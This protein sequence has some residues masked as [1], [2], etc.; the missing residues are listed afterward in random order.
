MLAARKATVNEAYL[1][2]LIRKNPKLALET[3]RSRKGYAEDEWGIGE[4]LREALERQAELATEAEVHE[5][6]AAQEREQIG[7]AIDTTAEL[8]KLN[9]DVGVPPSAY[10][11]VRDA[12]KVDHATGRR[13]EAEVDNA[14]SASMRRAERH[15]HVGSALAEGRNVKWVGEN[16]ESLDAHIEAIA[17][18]GSDETTAISRRVRMAMIAGTTPPKMQGHILKS[19]RARDPATR[20]AGVR[21]LRMLEDADETGALT[22]WVPADRR[23]FGRRFTAL[24]ASGYS[25]AEAL[26]RL[27]GADSASPV[28]E[29]AR[30]HHF[31]THV[32]L[33]DVVDAVGRAFGIEPN[34]IG[35]Y[36]AEAAE[37]RPESIIPTNA[38]APRSDW[39]PL[40]SDSR[41]EDL[42]SGE[43]LKKSDTQER[44][45]D[46]S[47]GNVAET[48]N[49]AVAGASP[50]DTTLGR[51]GMQVKGK[52]RYV[53]TRYGWVDLQHVIS[54]A[55][56]T[57]DPALNVILGIVTEGA[58]TIWPKYWPS[59]W[60]KEDLLSN[61]IG[62]Q[63][64]ARQRLVGGTIG[65]AV[66][67]VLRR[68]DPLTKEEAEKFLATGGKAE[69]WHDVIG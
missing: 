40:G 12:Y 52:G 14:R 2:G 25:D 31:D 45:G 46:Y 22:A 37:R 15:N 1:L 3:L 33:D 61:W 56:A 62:A 60:K 64:L 50:W 21:M 26:K 28:L 59:A 63:A 39:S 68:Y 44:F 57:N 20:A 16:L 66:A 43:R 38:A 29:E 67:F 36:D 6:T 24:T 17:N 5:Q 9:F 55:T 41:S 32:R 34:G 35:E 10:N 8:A 69:R 27:D 11:H 30:R 65:D 13:L 58:Q 23:A 49:K 7:L 19:L 48:V 42:T 51:A 4:P 47:A 54:A 18:D 53:W